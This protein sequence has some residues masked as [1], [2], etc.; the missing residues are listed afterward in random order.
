[1]IRPQLAVLA[2]ATLVILVASYLIFARL[3]VFPPLVPGLVACVSAGIL[4][5]TRSL[6]Q[7]WA[8]DGVRVNGIAPGLV[9]TKLTKVTMDRPDRLQGAL[10]SIPAGRLGLPEDMAG[11]ALFLASPLA[12]YIVGQT[13]VVDGGQML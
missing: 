4:G 3:L 12:S 7:A 5:L 8:P 10:R 11:A 2:G 6:G 9:D 1:M 13:L